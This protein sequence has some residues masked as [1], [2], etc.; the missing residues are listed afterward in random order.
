DFSDVNLSATTAN[1][2]TKITAL[3]SALN[4]AHLVDGATHTLINATTASTAMVNYITS[5]ALKNDKKFTQAYLSGKT[6]YVVSHWDPEGWVPFTTTFHSNGTLSYYDAPDANETMDYTVL[7]NG[8]IKV[9]SRSSNPDYTTTIKT[10]TDD[11]IETTSTD[12]LSTSEYFFLD[13]AKA[14][15]KLASLQ[16]TTVSVGSGFGAEWLN[17]RTL[18]FVILDTEDDNHNGS[19]ADHILVARAFSNGNTTL[20]FDADG[21]DI[22][23]NG[24][25]YTLI[26]GAIKILYGSDWEQN[27][28]TVINGDKITTTFTASWGSPTTEYLFT[29][30]LS[31]QAYLAQL[32]P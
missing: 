11:Y 12:Q 3:L 18:W 8:S 30:K 4:T 25:T 28:I 24:G 17:N 10:V 26:N 9:T 16:S 1:M 7:T 23:V 15:A 5:N 6:F 21:R 31:A 19:T 27:K 2:E 13:K 20:D 32:V 22:V 14:D 29:T